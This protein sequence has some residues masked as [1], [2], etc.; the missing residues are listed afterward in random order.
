MSSG[1]HN[2]QSPTQVG[3][4]TR[5]SVAC[6]AGRAARVGLRSGRRGGRH[7]TAEKLWARTDKTSSPH[8]CWIVSGTVVHSG[9]VQIKRKAEGLPAVRAHRLAWELLRGPVPEGLS[10]LHNCPG[11]D[12]PRCVNPAHLWLGSQAEN[13]HD[14]IRKGR[15]NTFGI[16]KL[17]AAQVREIR[18]LLA[19]GLRHKDIAARFGIARNTVTGIAARKSWDHLD[20][21]FESPSVERVPFV[22]LPVV[23]EVR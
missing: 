12:N 23:G 15:Y 1:K 20:R 11:G 16:Q 3:L 14:S 9:H 8:G 7:S 13:V 5:Q 6:D 17:N 2:N 10:V 18:G 4:A 21:P 22:E 19:R